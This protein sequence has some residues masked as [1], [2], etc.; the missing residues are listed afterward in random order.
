[1]NIEPNFIETN[2]N[3]SS[4]MESGNSNTGSFDG[5]LKK[6]E[7]GTLSTITTVLAIMSTI[8]GGGM[9]SIPWAFYNTGFYLAIIISIFA[10]A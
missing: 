9:V 5:A 2:L 3:R 6:E 7:V 4:I 1:M 10:S 8:V